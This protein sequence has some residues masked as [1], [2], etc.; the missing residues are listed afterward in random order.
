DPSVTI[1][2]PTN[3]QTL[4]FNQLL[5]AFRVISGDPFATTTVTDSGSGGVRSVSYPGFIG[6][7][8][9]TWVGGLL[10][11]GTSTLTVAV[12]DCH[13]SAQAA[14]TIEYTPIAADERFNVLGFEATQ[15]IQSLPDSIPLVADKPTLVRVYLNVLGSTSTVNSVRG[16]L[17]GYRPLNS[18]FDKG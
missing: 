13:G 6:T 16:T 12:Q 5:L 7:F 9:P 3:G 4:Q 15:A 1:S 17:I 18:Q 14:V 10:V 11:E 2:Q 8:G